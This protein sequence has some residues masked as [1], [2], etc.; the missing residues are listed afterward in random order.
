MATRADGSPAVRER[1]EL[2]ATANNGQRT[3]VNKIIVT[4]R[5]GKI[6]ETLN[7]NDD[8]K[9]LKFTVCH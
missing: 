7:I 1:V 5:N 9:C 2:T 6:S 8:V 4:D 3:L